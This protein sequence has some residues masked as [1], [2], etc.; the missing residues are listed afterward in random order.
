MG[1]FDLSFAVIKDINGLFGKT[2]LAVISRGPG[3]NTKWVE[4]KMI[5]YEAIRSASASKFSKK[6]VRS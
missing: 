1:T 5:G 2:A 3:T 6:L 4:R